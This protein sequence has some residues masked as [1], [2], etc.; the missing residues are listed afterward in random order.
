MAK[1]YRVTP[2]VRVSNALVA[3]RFAFF[4]PDDV[5]ARLRTA[6]L[7]VA[8]VTMRNPYDQVEYPSKRAYILARKPDEQQM[9][10]AAETPARDETAETRR[11]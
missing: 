3:A 1:T 6:G 11:R 5:V 2:F 9:T 7:E 10:N 4:Q 8:E